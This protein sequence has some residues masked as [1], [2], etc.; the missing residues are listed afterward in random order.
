[1]IAAK[2]YRA[3]RPCC[4]STL[5]DVVHRPVLLALACAACALTPPTGAAAAESDLQPAFSY[6]GTDCVEPG[7]TV[8]V[9]V[10]RARAAVPEPYVPSSLSGEADRADVV[11]LVAECG[12]LDLDGRT[13]AGRTVVDAGV[14]IESPDFSGGVH[15]YQLWHLSDAPAISE[16]MA[17]VGVRGGHV[18]DLAVEDAGAGPLERATATVPWA[19]SPF[20]LAVDAAVSGST[21]AT[22]TWWHRGPHGVV[23]L[24][25]GFPRNSTQT[26]TGRVNAR[27]GTPLA[28]LIGGTQADGFGAI[29]RLDFAGTV[30]TEP[31]GTKTPPASGE[32]R[33]PEGNGVTPRRRALRVV[34]RPSRV[35]AG[36]RVRLTARVTAGARP[37]RRALVRLAGRRARTDARGRARLTVR[38]RPGR[39]RVSVSRRGARGARTHVVATARARR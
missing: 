11:L 4:P 16:R 5:R 1:M 32:T 39:H 20:D 36:R 29:G 2:A 23:R 34:V 21:F 13:V 8:S 28:A 24:R 26:G 3:M 15:L 22:A 10:D 38:L 33:P 27:A 37:V 12:A 25:Y 17:A 18:G 30:A 7:V 35:R 9:P 31:R 6:G 14:V 19:T